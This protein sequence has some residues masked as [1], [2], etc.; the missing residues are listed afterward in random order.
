MLSKTIA[1]YNEINSESERGE[2]VVKTFS[3]A[4]YRVT[5]SDDGGVTMMRDAKDVIDGSLRQDNE[6]INVLFFK[7]RIGHSALF[8]LEGLEN[9]VLEAQGEHITTRTT[10]RVESIDKI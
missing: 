1:I 4:S 3:G 6:T 9:P 2:Y 10:S 7:A 8:I 5:I